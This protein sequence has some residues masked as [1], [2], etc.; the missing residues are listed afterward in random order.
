MKAVLALLA[1]AALLAGPSIADAAQEQM[2]APLAQATRQAMS[3]AP[4]IEVRISSVATGDELTWIARTSGGQR[5]LC[6]V[7][8]AARVS[9]G[10]VACARL[11]ATASQRLAVSE[12]YKVMT[13]ANLQSSQ[14]RRASVPVYPSSWAAGYY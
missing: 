11:T 13:E 14:A 12:R 5:Y 6:S 2:D 8:A 10:T 7:P 3:V 9:A 1:P 4:W